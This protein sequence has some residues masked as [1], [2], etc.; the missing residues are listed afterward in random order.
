[1][2]A[3]TRRRRRRSPLP[4]P[5]CRRPRFSRARCRPPPRGSARPTQTQISTRFKIRPSTPI[6]AAAS[7]SAPA[8]VPTLTSIQARL[9]STHRSRFQPRPTPPLRRS[10]RTFLLPSTSVRSFPEASECP[11]ASAGS[12]TSF[13]PTCL[14]SR[15]HCAPRRTTATCGRATPAPPHLHASSRLT[16]TAKPPPSDPTRPSTKCPKLQTS[17]IRLCRP[18]SMVPVTDKIPL[19][20]NR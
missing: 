10:N 14:A 12:S 16:P 5:R 11:A 15:P 3:R 19:I 13:R 7:T 2:T 9:F 17:R 18:E 6:R 4:S 20:R 8:R 1:M